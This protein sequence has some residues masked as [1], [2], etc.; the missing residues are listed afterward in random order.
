MQD[1]WERWKSEFF[2]N[3]LMY[4]KSMIDACEE[5]KSPIE[6]IMYLGLMQLA[7]SYGAFNFTIYPQQKI[8]DYT[9]DFLIVYGD[10]YIVIECDGHEWHE[11]TKEQASKDKK[12]D[13]E[14]QKE[15]Y[16][17]FR[18]SGSDVN[19]EPEKV[20]YDVQKVF[21]HPKWAA[22]EAKVK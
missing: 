15:G 11:K 18:Y 10:K 14:L 17:V 13:R 5:F 7:F 2:A 16:I 22:S 3:Q 21:G 20:C 1:I 4:F 12:R 6:K 8:L 9:V 19:K